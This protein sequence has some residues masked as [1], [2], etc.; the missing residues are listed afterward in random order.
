MAPEVQIL[1]LPLPRVYETWKK[2]KL[3][4][5]MIQRLPPSISEKQS[6]C[7]PYKGIHGV[8]SQMVRRLVVSQCLAGSIPVLPIFASAK[9]DAAVI[10]W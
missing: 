1:S 6:S 4:R 9:Q 2:A 8:G 5:K 10:Q 7:S 3:D